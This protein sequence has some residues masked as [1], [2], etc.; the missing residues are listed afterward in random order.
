MLAD[1]QLPVAKAL[2][3]GAQ[4]AS[5]LEAAHAGGIVHRDIKP[6]NVIVTPDGRAKVLDF[7]LAKLFE[8]A[9]ESGHDDGIRHASG[10]GHG[11]A[12]VHVAGAGRRTD[13]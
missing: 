1:G 9:S 13:G 11:N 8:R 12:G 5:A 10:P 2:D 6:A 7:G 3:L 4:I